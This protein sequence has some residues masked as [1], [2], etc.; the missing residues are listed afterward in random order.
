MIELEVALQ[1]A[2]DECSA[3]LCVFEQ[4]R[5]LVGVAPARSTKEC[6]PRKQVYYAVT[7]RIRMPHVSKD[8]WQVPLI[9]RHEAVDCPTYHGYVA[10]SASGEEWYGPT[11]IRQ[12]HPPKTI[13][14]LA[15]FDAPRNA[16]DPAEIHRPAEK[17]ESPLCYL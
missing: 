17:P 1:I 14:V 7:C 2:Q 12:R 9:L 13:V 5:E 11:Q 16:I 3:E 8:A 15:H 10:G 4:N 6:V